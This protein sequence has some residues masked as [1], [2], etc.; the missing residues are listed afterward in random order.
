MDKPK[1]WWGNSK[2]AKEWIEQG[3]KRT[4]GEG[5]NTTSE[6]TNIVVDEISKNIR[7]FKT[8]L[9]VGA[10]DGRLIGPL[11]KKYPKKE[12]QSADINNDLCIYI[13]KKYCNVVVNYLEE[14]VID[15][16]LFPDNYFDLVYTYQVL[17]HVHPD[18]IEKALEE[19]QRVS[20]K[21]VWLWE[22]IGREDYE[23]GAMV[24]KAHNG[25]WVWKID[26]MVKCEVNIPKNDKI[27]L[28]RQRLYKIKK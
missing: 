27:E 3:K 11:S 22:G 6:S 12:F 13:S 9:E 5:V 24:H 14:G 15:L 26:E 10:G 19:L 16:S 18:E 25:S 21:E 23:H 8:I 17:Q 4:K 7:S 28:S 1:D 2:N 20:K